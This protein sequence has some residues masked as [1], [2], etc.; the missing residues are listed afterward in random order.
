MSLKLGL[1]VQRMNDDWRSR[2]ECLIHKIHRIS[3]SEDLSLQIQQMINPDSPFIVAFINAH[4]MNETVER[5]DFYEALR[6]SDMLLRDGSGVAMLYKKLAMNPGLNL[7]GTDLI[8]KI[9]KASNGKKLALYGTQEP[10]LH[11]AKTQVNTALAPESI[12][13]TQHGFHELPVYVKEAN[14]EKPDVIVLA[15]GMPKQ[16]ILANKLKQ[17]LNHP[18]LIIC[19]GAIV[20]FLAGRVSRAPAWMR[21]IGMEWIYRLMLE[22]K[23]LFKRYVIGNPLFLYRAFLSIKRIKNDQKNYPSAS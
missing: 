16:E 19:G 2:W 20:D 4:A 1:L 17:E 7:N 8:P 3:S 9:L 10:Y 21:K 18:C 11:Q 5:T 15:M 23:R 22:P 12:V 13:Q 6:S 14:K